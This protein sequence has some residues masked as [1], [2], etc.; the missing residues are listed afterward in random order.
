[1]QWL[2]LPLCTP[3]VNVG[4]ALLHV[5]GLRHVTHIGLGG[6]GCL[7]ASGLAWQ[8]LCKKLC[9]KPAK[10]LQHRGLS[11]ASK[12]PMLLVPMHNE[13]AGLADGLG[14]GGALAFG[15]L[16]KETPAISGLNLGRVISGEVW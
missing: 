8:V 16:K 1:M 6:G 10:H 2:V 5:P 3:H 15:D 14:S 9:I 12:Q 13:C 4:L 11:D 7:L